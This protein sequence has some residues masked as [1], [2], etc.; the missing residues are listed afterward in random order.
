MTTFLEAHLELFG[1]FA[2]FV[3]LGIISVI[4]LALCRKDHVRTGVRL[5]SFGFFL[6]ARGNNGG[7]KSKKPRV[8]QQ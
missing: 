4:L 7:P 5:R 8:L 2:I 3:A 1:L 6:E